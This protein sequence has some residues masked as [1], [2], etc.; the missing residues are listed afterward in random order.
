MT[1]PTNFK[2]PQGLDHDT[3]R[4][5]SH[6]SFKKIVVFP[7]WGK[8]LQLIDPRD[9]Q[10]LSIQGAAVVMVET[11]CCANKWCSIKEFENS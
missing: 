2:I 9:G 7:E 1:I 4:N 10:M 11:Y 8:R 5:P 6:S 3:Q